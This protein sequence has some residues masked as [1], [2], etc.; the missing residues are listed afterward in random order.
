ML[1]YG[2]DGEASAK[3]AAVPA[4]HGSP[5]YTT[6]DDYGPEHDRMC[7]TPALELSQAGRGTDTG[8][9]SELGVVSDVGQPLPRPTRGVAVAGHRHGRVASG[10]AADA[11][12]E[13]AGGET[14]AL[15]VCQ[16]SAA[17]TPWGI[18][19]KGGYDATLVPYVVAVAAGGVGTNNPTSADGDAPPSTDQQG[20]APSFVACDVACPPSTRDGR[21]PPAVQGHG[22]TYHGVDMAAHF[23]RT[24]GPHGQLVRRAHWRCHHCSARVVGAPSKLGQHLGN[25]QGVSLAARLR[26]NAAAL[27]F[28]A[29]NPD[30]FG[31]RALSRSF[32][33]TGWSR[34]Q[35][36]TCGVALAGLNRKLR[37]HL[38][39][40]ERCDVAAPR[41]SATTPSAPQSPS[42]PRASARL[43]A[44]RKRGAVAR[45]S[46]PELHRGRKHKA[47][48]ARRTS[49]ASSTRSSGAAHPV[50]CTCACKIC[51]GCAHAGVT[52]D[53]GVQPAPTSTARQLSVADHFE[54]ALT[55]ELGSSV[56]RHCGACVEATDITQLRRH[57]GTCT[58]LS[59]AHR[60]ALDAA[61]RSDAR[62]GR[63][64][65]SARSHVAFKIIG[66]ERAECQGCGGVVAGPISD[67]ERHW[68]RCCAQRGVLARAVPTAAHVALAT[69]EASS[70]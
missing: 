32:I 54:V 7:A 10:E 14:G 48:R 23:E 3:A 2:S 21:V 58:Q 33:V 57:L 55:A 4:T 26:L 9:R 49:R 45:Q 70:T 39:Q 40:S 29:A 24:R 62:A 37:T 36:R 25:C 65:Y 43:R 63:R 18:Q 16:H 42:T 35:C 47:K 44:V 38:E 69:T 15:Y 52:A 59:P 53:S 22:T 1:A 6:V 60:G 5:P 51:L 12:W 28:F 34:A 31:D 61:A 46:A 27:A 19:H 67:L 11:V 68:T 30:P 17:A 8:I 50:A 56:C 41:R 64:H 66:W 20:R 13:W